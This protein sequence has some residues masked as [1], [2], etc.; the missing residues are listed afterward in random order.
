[1]MN[2]K[3]IQSN[4]CWIEG[5]LQPATVYFDEGIIVEVIKGTTND[6]SVEDV[7]DRV[8]MPGV[9]DAHVHINEPGRTDW[10]GFNSGTQAAAAGG[11]TTIVDMPLNASPV[12]VNKEALEVKL[13]STTKQL[14]VNAGFYAGLIPGSLPRLPPLLQAGVLGVKVFLTHSGINEFPNVTVSDLE[15]AMPVI[16]QY[17]VPLLVHCELMDKTAN[18]LYQ[19]PTQYQAYLN[20]RPKAWEN[21]AVATMIE[22]CRKHQCKMHVVHVSSAEALQMIESAKQEGLPVTAETCPHYIYFKAEEIPDGNTL[23]KCAPPIRE[24]QNNEALKQALATGTLNFLASD[25]S[26]APPTYKELDSGN[27]LKAWGGIAGLQFLLSA[28]WSAL[29]NTIS[30]EQFI[31]LVTEHPAAF[32]GIG[33]SKGTIKQGA[34]AD[35]V[36]WSP[37][38]SF[39]VETNQVLHKHPQTVYAGQQLFG[40]VY[41]TYVNGTLVYNN[42][43]IINKNAGKWLLKK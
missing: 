3:G 27:L 5:S 20:S 35:L 43:K 26:P 22:L 33:S 8:L 28:G 40:K 39:K 36:V 14:H 12:T 34:D 42:E 25:H 31:P 7:G 24:Q 29:K 38:E 23:Y 17:D 16:K 6:P 9:I 19:Q 18:S 15:E 41:Q 13:L 32:L 1:M 21:A 11:T 4:C 10:E 37:E 2:K 30:I